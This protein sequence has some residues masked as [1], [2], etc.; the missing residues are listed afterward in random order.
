V[1]SMCETGPEGI[2]LSII[3]TQAKKVRYESAF[4]S[5]D[6]PRDELSLETVPYDWPGHRESSVGAL[7]QCKQASVPNCKHHS[8]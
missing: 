6:C 1:P 5:V 2:T 4:K 7:H 3:K 8:Y